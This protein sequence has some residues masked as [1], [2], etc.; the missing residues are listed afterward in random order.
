MSTIFFGSFYRCVFSS[1]MRE[2][3]SIGA[4]IFQLKYK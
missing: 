4:H 1:S 2:K 3:A